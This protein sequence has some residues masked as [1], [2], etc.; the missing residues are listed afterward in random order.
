VLIR[1][2]QRIKLFVLANS[3]LTGMALTSGLLTIVANRSGVGWSW[4]TSDYVAV[5]KNFASGNG[6]LDAT[7]IPMTVRPP[8]LSIL[9]GLGDLLGLSVNLSVQVL[10]AIC[11]IVTVFGTFHLLQIAK[12]R[13]SIALTAAA[14]VAFSPALLWQYSM[15]WSEPPFIALLIIAMIISLQ[16]MSNLKF[17]SLTF[18]FIALFFVRYVG[19]VF[20]V[21]IAVCSALFD[22]RQLGLFKSI[23]TN[24]LTLAI[25]L[26]PVWLWLGRNKRIDGT[27]TGARAPGGGSLVDPLKTFN[28]TIGSWL[29]GSPVE[30]SIYMSWVD[31]SS[32][33]RA[34]GTMLVIL[35]A[36]LLIFYFYL[37][38]R[39]HQLAELSNVLLLGIGITAVYVAFSA[40][41]FVHF[42][43]GPLDNRMMIPVFV[44]I[45]LIVAITIDNVRINARWLRQSVATL[46]VAFVAFQALSSTTDA[47]S[48]GRDGRHWAGKTIKDQPI[49]RFV[50]SLPIDSSLMSNQPQ[51]LYSVWQQSSVYNQY[52]LDLAQTADCD[53]RYFVWYNSTYN[54]GTPN[55]EGQPENA[56]TI[57]ADASGIVFD[58]GRCN[59]D[60]NK[61]WP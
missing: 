59:S 25:S 12:V 27:L 41:R 39:N 6:L 58:L 33:T 2:S 42:E 21:T 37:Q 34:L 29:T 49:H 5:A 1:F 31:Y 43:L 28:A 10:N 54:D 9:I 53:R 7:G 38:T 40:Y 35:V 55:V 14:F 18:L 23:S 45:V 44:P 57:Y 3:W 8:G 20:A 36:I 15:I 16:P 19:P 13:K 4:D 11:A 48:F 51:Q 26:L 17:S 56:P 30:G 60:I 46:F 52:Q 32:V 47:L 61:Y 22:R 24:F 50:M